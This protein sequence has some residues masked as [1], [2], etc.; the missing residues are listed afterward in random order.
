M[1]LDKNILENNIK[2]RVKT[3][4]PLNQDT[5][6]EVAKVFA[7]EIDSYL[8]Q[9]VISVTIPALQ[10]ANNATEQITINA[11]IE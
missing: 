11:E 8:K 4:N 9:A 1:A 6:A 2:A 3:I 7:E 5:I 10:V